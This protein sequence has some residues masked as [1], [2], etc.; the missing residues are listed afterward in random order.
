M[1][2]HFN[3]R[4]WLASVI[5]ALFLVLTIWGW[6]IAL[7]IKTFS[8][9][10]NF[11]A[12]IVGQRPT[13]VLL[14]W[15]LAEAAL[16][17]LLLQLWR[18]RRREQQLL[19]YQQSE[20]TARRLETLIEALPDAIFFKDGEGCWQVVNSAGLRL[21]GLEGEA[22]RGKSDL[23]LA[24]RYP[25]ME[26]AY[27]NCALDDEQAWQR[28]ERFDNIEE[29]PDRNGVRTFEVSKVPLF[30]PDG[31]RQGLVV[32]GRDI[33]ERRRNEETTQR[34]LDSLRHLSE[35]AAL[36]HLPLD[37]RLRR[38]LTVG[39]NHLGLEFA[40]VSRVVGSEYRIVSQVSPPNTL[41]DNQLFE[42]AN[43]YCSITLAHN[44][45]LAI[46]E[47][48][49]SPYHGH[50]C[51]QSV[52][53]ECY[54][55]AP[56]TVGD[57]VYGT[58]NFSSP[59]PYR[60][61]FDDGDREFV[62]LLARWVGSTLEAHLAAQSLAAN[63]LQLQTIIDNE[64]GCVK[65]LDR[66]GRVLQMNRAGLEMIEAD[67]LD[68]VLGCDLAELVLPP[69]RGAFTNLTQRVFAGESAT[70]EFQLRGLKNNQRWLE[71]H[72]VPLRTPAG[73]I[74]ALLAVTLD[75]TERKAAEAEIHRLAY[76]DP[77]T[78]LANRRLLLDRLQ[79][80]LRSCTR[81]NSLNALLVIDL[82]HFKAL[83]DGLGHLKGDQLL[84]EV[85]GRLTGSVRAD[86]TVA[87]IGGDEFVVVLENLD[88]DEHIAGRQVAEIAEKIRAATAR[89]YE[90]DAQRQYP[91]TASIGACLFSGDGGDLDVL[92]GHA[93][94]ALYQAKERGRDQVCLY[95]S[96]SPVV[97]LL[98]KWQADR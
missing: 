51:Y 68:Q 1:S 82:D 75:I 65:L 74:S 40:I 63:E 31:S 52:A 90:M 20:E 56:V 47:M 16:L 42:L 85:A 80:L 29:I 35:V 41:Q 27:R 89:P 23:E 66:E 49:D 37:E 67:S 88:P 76:F 18:R 95:Q 2:L 50:P 25:Q 84:Q 58:V 39:M 69:D 73:D 33:S 53:L 81:R 94:R 15:L 93:D 83:N 4:F 78:N 77:L 28:R 32:I 87:R 38:A 62:T 61:R 6:L 72:A 97:P 14:I 96:P 19:R 3:H 55:G 60:R 43:T 91:V 54:I 98:L 79:Q 9:L 10:S 11:E 48:G 5:L 8:F 34:L 26:E 71:T 21:F 46:N 86:D 45:V 92:F 30:K 13:L 70:L 59:T 64:P 36:S 57:Q 12:L 44:G 17:L 24:D 7:E 22:W